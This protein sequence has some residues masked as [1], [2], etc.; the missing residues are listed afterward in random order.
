M[1]FTRVA[2]VRIDGDCDCFIFDRVLAEMIAVSHSFLLPFLAASSVLIQECRRS[3]REIFSPPFL[4][5][6]VAPLEFPE[7]GLDLPI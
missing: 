3:V 4:P 2:I 1:C 7:Q 5:L 6:P